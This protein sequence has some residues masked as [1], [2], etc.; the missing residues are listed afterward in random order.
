MYQFSTEKHVDNPTQTL[1]WDW[2]YIV[3]NGN[4]EKFELD[5]KYVSLNIS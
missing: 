2:G 3:I 4:S 1:W 5:L